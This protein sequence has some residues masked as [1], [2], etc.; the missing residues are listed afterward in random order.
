MGNVGIAYAISIDVVKSFLQ[1]ASR[2]KISSQP[3]LEKE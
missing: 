3:S 2:G 1:D